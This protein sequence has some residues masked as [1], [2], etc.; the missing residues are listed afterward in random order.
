MGATVVAPQAERFV[1]LHD[2][3]WETYERLLSEN[4]STRGKR[5]TYDNGTLQIRV[6]SRSHERPN[7]L[8]ELIVE[9]VAEEWDLSVDGSGA[10]TIKRADLLKGFEPDSCFYI[11]NADAVR[12]KAELDF[13]VDPPPDLLIE[14]DITSDSLDKFPIFA[15][16]GVPE[17]WRYAE[18]AL[19]IHVLR[20]GHYVEAPGSDMLP[21][22]TGEL[23]TS[24]VH[25]GLRERRPKW[26][27]RLRKWARSAARP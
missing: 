19:T 1:I 12:D 5:F 20:G 7:H 4:D 27:G 9:V 25:A 17:V 16:I 23:L 26:L 14:V 11:R 10:M 21:P 24:F 13:T 2:V 8:L 18:N 15:A 3:T 22:L 6:V